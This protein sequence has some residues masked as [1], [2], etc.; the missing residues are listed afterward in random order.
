ME[1]TSHESSKIQIPE[2]T[3]MLLFFRS[4]WRSPSFVFCRCFL[5]SFRS[6]RCLPC[7]CLFSIHYRGENRIF[8]GLNFFEPF[9]PIRS[10]SG[11]VLET[12]KHK[13]IGLRKESEQNIIQAI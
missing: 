9:H 11:H 5:P 6:H 3:G 4:V 1:S 2:Y 7:L 12:L 13:V 8:I 10:S